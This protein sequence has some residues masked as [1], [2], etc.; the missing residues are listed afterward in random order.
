MHDRALPSLLQADVAHG[1]ENGVQCQTPDAYGRRCLLA[2]G[3][4][5]AFA[6]LSGARHR[7][8]AEQPSDGEFLQLS[9]LLTGRSELDAETS[10][11]LN[12]A[13]TATHQ[14]FPA[15]VSACAS[16]ARAHG[17]ATVEPLAAALDAQ[18]PQLA[19]VLHAI[20]TAWYV[21]VAGDGPQAKVIAWREALMFD[22]VGGVLP[23]PSY[24]RAAPGYWTAK[25][26]ATA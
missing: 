10:W 3:A 26:S 9:K 16:F 5:A 15:Q 22:A 25:P 19:A 14:D 11:R 17:F 13:L 7:V 8:W 1:G 2:G 24:C 18:N 4:A 23:A 6:V 20:V 21:G 12:A